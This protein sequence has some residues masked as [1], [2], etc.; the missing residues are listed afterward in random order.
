[1]SRIRTLW[2]LTLFLFGC[3]LLS[4]GYMFSSSLKPNNVAK[5]DRLGSLLVNYADISIGAEKY[6]VILGEP[7]L[8]RRLE[9]EEFLIFSLIPRFS[10]SSYG[11]AIQK[12]NSEN[13]IYYS[14]TFL[15]PCRGV[16]YD[17][18]G[19]VVNGPPNALPMRKINYKIFDD[20]R[21]FIEPAT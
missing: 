13:A 11:C 7:Y 4:V 1:M 9:S 14:A 20:T 16:W 21:L 2:T 10:S 18:S 3:G 15:E 17:E 5:Y 19:Y 8:I 6:F 12:D